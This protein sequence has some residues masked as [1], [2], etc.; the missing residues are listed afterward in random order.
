MVIGLIEAPLCGHGLPASGNWQRFHG[1]PRLL[2]HLLGI[3]NRA[4]LA[5]LSED[6]LLGWADRYHGA[7]GGW[8]NLDSG[9][10][11]S[12]A[13]PTYAVLM[14]FGPEGFLL[15]YR[16]KWESASPPQRVA[17]KASTAAGKAL[18]HEV[19]FP[20]GDESG[21]SGQGWS[22]TGRGAVHTCTRCVGR[23]SQA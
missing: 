23:M 22:S 8:P 19:M 21:T 6:T 11:D 1:L 18:F 17:V 20:V 12:F 5:P 9:P 10:V 3:R 15:H 16:P 4:S 13:L 7:K 2:A 14:R